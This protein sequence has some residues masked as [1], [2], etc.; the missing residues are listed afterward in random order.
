MGKFHNMSCKVTELL[1]VSKCCDFKF[2]FILLS[3][4]YYILRNFNFTVMVI[5]NGLVVSNV[6]HTVLALRSQ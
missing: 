3:F 5:V 2:V 4:N 1:C 6:K